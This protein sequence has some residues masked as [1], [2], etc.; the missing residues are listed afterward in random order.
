MDWI[1]T[2]LGPVLDGLK[3]IFKKFRRPD[4]VEVL[5]RREKIQKD[6][7]SNLPRLNEYSNRGEA[8]IRNI[9]R[10]D[11]YPEINEKEKGIS[12]WFKVEIK[13][14]Y[15]RGVEVFIGIEAAAEVNGQWK[16][17][18]NKKR[19]EDSTNVFLVGHIPFDS[20]EYINWNGDQYYN[21]PHIFCKFNGLQ[22]GPYEAIPIYFRSEAGHFFEI[23]GFRPLDKYRKFGRWVN[24]RRKK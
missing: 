22:G 17:Q 1:S 5:K 6:F 7:E 2:F 3:W 19:T 21:F 11:S 4:S 18:D 14:L 13:G 9:K 12:S 16:L 23:E 8:I 24:K 20:I 15:H 10:F